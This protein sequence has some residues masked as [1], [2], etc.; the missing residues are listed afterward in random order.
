MNLSHL[1]IRNALARLYATSSYTVYHSCLNMNHFHSTESSRL[2]I[3]SFNALTSVS[4]GPQGDKPTLKLNFSKLGVNQI[5]KASTTEYETEPA[6]NV[7]LSLHETVQETPELKVCLKLQTFLLLTLQY[8][9]G[10]ILHHQRVS[11]ELSND[12]Y[13]AVHLAIDG[14]EDFDTAKVVELSVVLCGDEY[15]RELNNEWLGKNEA[16]DVLS[17][18]QFQEPGISPI[19]RSQVA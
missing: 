2:K 12:A 5:A 16:T 3:Q 19:V 11:E 4:K 6:V 14:F 10:L 17:F 18:P 15:I 8:Y 13:Q 1:K 9:F 7:E